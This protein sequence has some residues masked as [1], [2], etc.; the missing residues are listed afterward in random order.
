M[1]KLKTL[2][3]QGFQPYNSYCKRWDL[4]PHDIAATRSLV[5]PVCQFQHSC[6]SINYPISFV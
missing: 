5:W 4:N 6:L 1:K 3:S 2:T